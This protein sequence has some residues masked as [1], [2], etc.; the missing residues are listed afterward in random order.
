MYA[1]RPVFEHESR[2]F[3]SRASIWQR[4]PK[5]IGWGLWLMV[6]IGHASIHRKHF[7]SS[8]MAAPL[9]THTSLPASH[10]IFPHPPFPHLLSIG[11]ISG[12]RPFLSFLVIATSNEREQLHSHLRHLIGTHKNTPNHII[13]SIPISSYHV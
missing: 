3:C 8:G 13:Q 9:T 12:V 5:M 6:G 11:E 2:D 10:S 7:L 4:K 1:L